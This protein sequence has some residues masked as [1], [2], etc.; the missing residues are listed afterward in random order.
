VDGD[1][2]GALINGEEERIQLIGRDTLGSA[3]LSLTFVS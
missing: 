1:T 3:A 2:S